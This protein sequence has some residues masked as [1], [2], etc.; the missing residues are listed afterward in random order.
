M[1]K[2]IGIAAIAGLIAAPA[3]AADMAVKAARAPAPVANWT[4]CYVGAN[5][6]GGW[7]RNSVLDF[8]A[9]FNAGSDTGSGIVGGGQVGCDYQF[10]NNWVVGIQDMLDGASIKGSHIYPGTL[11]ETLGA[12]TRWIDTLTGRLGY[13]VTPQTL[14]YLKGGGAWARINYTDSN[15]IAAPPVPAYA[16]QG[17]AT[18]SGW[19]LGG[20]AEYAFLRNWSAF[21]EYDYIDLGS[22]NVS[23][24]YNCGAACFFANPYT[25]RISHN[26]SELLLGINYRFR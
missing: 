22:R 20:G 10:A 2:I 12:N 5:V 4:G 14:L 11:T 16:G 1:M 18:R 17:N 21:A 3:L 13:T 15:P 23:L 19:T 7:Q 8:L 9:G 6:G 26:V 24:T 25:Y